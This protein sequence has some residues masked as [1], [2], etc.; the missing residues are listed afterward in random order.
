MSN[1]QQTKP[2]AL[3]INVRAL[4]FLVVLSACYPALQIALLRAGHN[5][6]GSATTGLDK[7][8]SV[9]AAT[10]LSLVALFLINKYIAKT[11]PAVL[12]IL[13]AATFFAYFY[14]IRSPF[15]P[16]ATLI[17]VGSYWP[18]LI[19]M[20]LAVLGP[21]IVGLLMQLWP[22]NSFK[23]TPLRGAA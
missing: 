11:A 14:L 23:P 15:D 1:L 17:S 12:G 18:S 20:L 8:L 16:L 4:G 10:S 2:K 13:A 9:L 6:F 21:V 5:L 3:A 7:V 19:N 22:N